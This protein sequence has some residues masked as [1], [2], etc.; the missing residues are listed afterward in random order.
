MSK[1]KSDRLEDGSNAINRS[2]LMELRGIF[3][4][5]RAIGNPMMCANQRNIIHKVAMIKNVFEMVCCKNFHQPTQ[6]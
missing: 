4:I 6:E 5:K 2:C 1:H 3:G